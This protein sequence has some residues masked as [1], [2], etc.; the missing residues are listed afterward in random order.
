MERNGA[1]DR[2]NT[3]KGNTNDK[4]PAIKKSI[5]VQMSVEKNS[6]YNW[7]ISLYAFAKAFADTV[8]AFAGHLVK[9]T[10]SR[11]FRGERGEAYLGPEGYCFR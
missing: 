11:T 7:L 1:K 3:K 10:L 5:I 2:K 6:F 8:L 9:Q 4:P